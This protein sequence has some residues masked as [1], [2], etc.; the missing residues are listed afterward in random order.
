MP[1]SVLSP[2][3]CANAASATSRVKVVR[4]A[5]QVRNVARKPC[6]V[7]SVRFIRLSTAIID[8]G[9]SGRSEGR[10][11]NTAGCHCA[12][13]VRAQALAKRPVDKVE[14]DAPRK[15][16]IRSAGTLP[17]SSGGHINLLPSRAEYLVSP[18]GGRRWRTPR[19]APRHPLPRARRTAKCRSFIIR[20]RSVT[21][22][23]A[24]LAELWQRLI[25]LGGESRGV[26][27]GGIVGIG[28][29]IQHGLDAPPDATRGFRLL[30]PDRAQHCNDMRGRDCAVGK[31][32]ITGKA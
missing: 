20:Q 30:N 5:A 32:P 23:A 24:R 29:V 3:T 19:R 12:A 17:M 2:T 18:R 8:A 11:G 21:R 15:A 25:Q 10:L 4:S 26:A 13:S 1:D 22:W 14:R 27:V 7:R 28:R 16:F 31:S 6:T 9:D